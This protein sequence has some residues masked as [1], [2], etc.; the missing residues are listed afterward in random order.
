MNRSIEFGYYPHPIDCE[1][2]DIQVTTLPDLHEAVSDV[3][4]DEGV[5][6]GWIYAPIQC[7][8]DLL[9]DALIRHPYSSRVF[10][11]PKTHLLQHAS[12][13]NG[14]HLSFLIWIL[15]FILGIRLTDTDAGFLDATP[16]EPGKLHDIV[17]L[18]PESPCRALEHAE[19]FWTAQSGRP[20]VPK[21]VTAI[22]HAFFLSQ[23]PRALSFERFTYLYIALDGC[24]LVHS[25][26]KGV[27]PRRGTHRRRVE[28]LCNAFGMPVPVWADSTL[29]NNVAARRNETLHE[30]LFFDEPLGFSVYG[31]NL[32]ACERGNTVL[33]MQGLVSRLL[34]AILGLPDQT[35]IA[36]PVNG[37]QQ[38]GMDL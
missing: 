28:A 16:I 29:S 6:N 19:R 13:D 2:G 9:S 3:A 18:G 36:S 21:A 1:V 26:M 30:G 31:G 15:G 14:E 20:R 24:H 10:G 17:L 34:C 11:L 7:S 38:H 22:I 12:A 25:L 32:P 8:D 37:R 35:Y 5:E 27:N 4:T 33:E 23:S